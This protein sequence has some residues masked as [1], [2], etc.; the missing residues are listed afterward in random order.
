MHPIWQE[1]TE[2]ALKNAGPGPFVV[3]N[4]LNARTSRGGMSHAWVV[5]LIQKSEEVGS[6]PFV[7][8]EGY[9]KLHGLTHFFPV[10]IPE[11]T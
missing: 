7:A 8:F 4:N 1:I 5:D 2:E 11:T 10:P 9:T 6:R 3:T